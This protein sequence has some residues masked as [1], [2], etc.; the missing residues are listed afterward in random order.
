MAVVKLRTI[1][2]KE[3][4][5]RFS[6]RSPGGNFID[7]TVRPLSPGAESAI[8]W[9]LL[10]IKCRYQPEVWNIPLKAILG[11][12][13]AIV[14]LQTD[15]PEISAYTG[16]LIDDNGLDVRVV[17]LNRHC[18]DRDQVSKKELVVTVLHELGHAFMSEDVDKS[19]DSG[20]EAIHD[21]GCYTALGFD[22]PADHWGLE[23]LGI[24]ITELPD[25]EKE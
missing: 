15:S 4:Y 22:I 3:N 1:S 6:V 9:A 5:A 17:I 12:A 13:T 23:K 11:A 2:M 16:H 21:I 25:E 18:F 20:E 19:S 8:Q 7:I 14:F 24:D 10:Q